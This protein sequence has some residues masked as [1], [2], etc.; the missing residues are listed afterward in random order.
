MAM[1]LYAPS[2]RREGGRRGP[3]RQERAVAAAAGQRIPRAAGTAAA[4]GVYNVKRDEAAHGVTASAAGHM[5]PLSSKDHSKSARTKRPSSAPGP[6][7]SIE[8]QPSCEEIRRDRPQSAAAM[9]AALTQSAAAKHRGAGHK[10]MSARAAVA[11][12]SSSES[13]ERSLER[14]P[15]TRTARVY[16]M[17]V[18]EHRPATAQ[19]IHE[20]KQTAPG[21]PFI[22]HMEPLTTDTVRVTWRQ[23]MSDGG[24]P[25]SGFRLQFREVAAQPETVAMFCSVASPADLPSWAKAGD[26]HRARESIY[27][28]STTE[29]PLSTSSVTG[30]DV[31]L[32]ELTHLRPAGS[33][34][35]RLCA[36]NSVGFGRW[37]TFK[38]FDL[39]TRLSLRVERSR[40]AQDGLL[41]HWALPARSKPVNF[42][43][44]F[45]PARGSVD[46]PSASQASVW[47]AVDGDAEDGFKTIVVKAT[48]S[49]LKPPEQKQVAVRELAAAV[50]GRG[51]RKKGNRAKLRKTKRVLQTV[52]KAEPAAEPDSG[53]AEHE[54]MLAGLTMHSVYVLR[55]REVYADEHVGRWTAAVRGR[56]LPP[57]PRAPTITK[58]DASSKAI[59]V[60]WEAAEEDEL[61]RYSLQ[62]V[63]TEGSNVGT[64][65][66]DRAEMVNKRGEDVA[67]GARIHRCV[68]DRLSP[69]V[70][71]ALRVVSQN[72]GGSTSSPVASA[73]T[74]PHE[75]VPRIRQVEALPDDTQDE[76]ALS[77]SWHLES[78]MGPM[79][80]DDSAVF[81]V[82]YRL[83]PPA[84]DAST[85][86]EK[87]Q[88]AWQRVILAADIPPDGPNTQ[89]VRLADGI[90]PSTQYE[91]R[92]RASCSVGAGHWQATAEPVQTLLS[93]PQN[94]SVTA[95][96]T[97][98]EVSWNMPRIYGDGPG[99]QYEVHVSTVG[100]TG[101][102]GPVIKRA[103]AFATCTCVIQGLGPVQRYAICVRAQSGD[104]IS[105][106]SS[107]CVA[108]TEPAVTLDCFALAALSADVSWQLDASIPTLLRGWTLQHRVCDEPNAMV[109]VADDAYEA[110]P[111]FQVAGTE[112]ESSGELVVTPTKREGQNEDYTASFS[113]RERRGGR[114]SS[115]KKS[116]GKV[117]PNPRTRSPGTQLK[118][119]QLDGSTR[120]TKL[121][122]LMPGKS[123]AW[124]VIAH[125]ENGQHFVSAW[126]TFRTTA[127][128][129]QAPI[130]LRSKITDTA[131]CA[132]FSTPQDMGAP[133]GGFEADLEK[134]GGNHDTQKLPAHSDH[135]SF[136]DLEPGVSYTLRLRAYN[137]AGWCTSSNAV[138]LATSRFTRVPDAPQVTTS[139]VRATSMIIDL[140]MPDGSPGNRAKSFQVE[141]REAEGFRGWSI[142]KADDTQ[143]W[144]QQL[145]PGTR[146]EIRACARND[147]GQS[148]Y[149][150]VHEVCTDAGAPAAPRGLS[151]SSVGTE[152]AV[153]QWSPADS[154]GDTIRQYRITYW[155][156]GVPLGRQEKLMDLINHE[157]KTLNTTLAHLEPATKYCANICAKNS[158]GSSTASEKLLFM[159]AQID[160][161]AVE[162]MQEDDDDGDLAD[163][164]AG[165]QPSG[166]RVLRL[167][168][169]RIGTEIMD[170]A[171]TAI[172][173]PDVAQYVV[174]MALDECANHVKRV[175][176]SGATASRLDRVIEV[177]GGI[178]LHPED[179]ASDPE[180]IETALSANVLLVDEIEQALGG[181]GEDSTMW[182][183]MPMET[184]DG[185]TCEQMLRCALTD[186]S[187]DSWYQ[188]RVRCE[189][190]DGGVVAMS[191]PI[192]RRTNSS[193]T[194][195]LTLI[196][197]LVLD[198]DD[199]SSVSCTWA[200]DTLTS[201]APVD[202]YEVR[203]RISPSWQSKEAGSLAWQRYCTDLPVL[204][205]SGFSPGSR[206]EVSVRP[207][208][209]AAVGDWSRIKAIC[210]N[211]AAPNPP[212]L[213]ARRFQA[214]ATAVSV[215]W[216]APKIDGGLAVERYELR[217]QRLGHGSK[218]AVSIHAGKDG[219]AVNSATVCDLQP[220][221]RYE[222]HVRAANAVG[223]S[224]WS[225]TATVATPLPTIVADVR[226]ALSAD[227]PD[228]WLL[229]RMLLTE[230]ANRDVGETLERG[231]QEA[232]GEK[233]AEA[234]HTTH[235]DHW[236]LLRQLLPSV[237][238]APQL[239]GDTSAGSAAA[240]HAQLLWGDQAA[241]VSLVLPVP[242]V[243]NT[244]TV[245]SEL[246]HIYYDTYGYTIAE[247]IQGRFPPTLQPA[248][249]DGDVPGGNV[250][251]GLASALEHAIDAAT[252][253]SPAGGGATARLVRE[254]EKLLVEGVP[255]AD[256]KPAVAAI[257]RQAQQLEPSARQGLAALFEKRHDRA[258]LNVGG[259]SPS[260]EAI[261]WGAFRS[262]FGLL[263]D[264]DGSSSASGEKVTDPEQVAVQLSLLLETM[265]S[266]EL[267]HGLTG[268]QAQEEAAEQIASVMLQLLPSHVPLVAAAYAAQRSGARLQRDIASSFLLEG[269]GLLYLLR[270]LAGAYA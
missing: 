24:V 252:V 129:P 162:D 130:V 73:T 202:R 247:H 144:L 19:S 90:A 68:V 76:A 78:P 156:A 142:Q 263:L 221:S 92:V 44:Q 29:G 198:C 136:T 31:R 250:A 135:C 148:Q 208:G 145:S 127:A 205:L 209:R 138:T 206:V 201:G 258:L 157:A 43:L 71:Y 219:S 52:D 104:D 235:F 153:L 87:K 237:A 267:G 168:D 213:L 101:E 94:T 25:L 27:G 172:A 93:R 15:L 268:S 147:S 193:S 98:V 176:M 197:G 207:W 118:T 60:H 151:V 165:S 124:R 234:V 149:S 178:Q 66:I 264:G 37:T 171:W 105:Q 3:Q 146:M 55:M 48:L 50:R 199:S 238:Q 220:Q 18:A 2:R 233:L 28:A 97:S 82:E 177:L 74:E 128:V 5:W 248:L 114:R 132:F 45:R 126:G 191:D 7:G 216:R 200:A 241:V 30:G 61:C 256:S 75:A 57:P 108:R 214:Q 69:S 21:V 70:E 255:G 270:P 23:P 257:L 41:V 231:Y 4:A 47:S 266:T 203:Y 36:G 260:A 262:F 141:F 174:E 9:A 96:A 13:L 228:P 236:L 51:R 125:D 11:H 100:P 170:L 159:T 254:L 210:T 83:L 229:Y 123:H 16:K 154:H 34:A 187:E 17:A 59:V 77:V 121:I 180:Q 49:R 102:T 10:K 12:R 95:M 223:W 222:V 143:A 81:Q 249:M 226:E 32:V 173:T 217:C 253:D 212:K 155:P 109:N 40:S 79:D 117:S 115:A 166:D 244:R 139:D 239:L 242:S 53:A 62:C 259:G 120:S 225:P 215:V 204:E 152:E 39:P 64:V 224:D 179:D 251:F 134:F 137:T 35:V 160:A 245:V 22:L 89:A 103:S 86:T 46:E 8:W 112:E 230:V 150:E 261:A 140:S 99:L 192:T 33:Y 182:M 183:W 185:G 158:V 56:T 227:Q 190:A 133:I 211:F 20:A 38:S 189:D 67:C 58:C 218:P 106:L 240:L 107:A 196:E 1:S 186:L 110:A 91:V 122:G 169:E 72:V 194:M 88:S 80:G 195:P 116:P 65:T 188:L 232:Y 84:A 243:D 14:D 265:S 54:L 111:R 164:A 63:S 181:A 26:D 113:R 269:K 42:E 6:A 119:L 175:A 131:I 163:T 246:A 184:V 85:G 167:V 161:P